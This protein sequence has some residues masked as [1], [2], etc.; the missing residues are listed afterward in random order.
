MVSAE[1]P[2]DLQ[3]NSL[4]RRV[5]GAALGA[6]QRRALAVSAL[7]GVQPITRLASLLGVSRQFVYRQSALASDALDDAFAPCPKEDEVLFHLPVT[8]DW[9]H[10]FALSLVLIGHT[11]LRGVPEILQAV[12]DYHGLSVGSVHNLIRQAVEKARRIH[13]LED[14]RGIR[15]G[16]HD[17]I[18]QAGTPVL[19]G[20][21]LDSTYCYLLNAAEHCDETT[22]GVSLLDLSERGLHL[23]RVIADGGKALRAG[24]SAAWP[25]VPC[26]SDVF[27]AERDLSAVAY[28]LDNRAR[29]CSSARQSLER[30]MERARK[31]KAGCSLSKKLALARSEE[32]KAIS[33]A[34]DIRILADWMRQ[35]ILSGSGPDLPTRR[36]LFDFVVAELRSREPL[37]PHRIGPVLKSLGNQRAGLLAFAGLLDRKL[38]SIAERFGLPAFLVHAVCELQGVDQ[39]SSAYWQRE[40]GLRTKLRHR[41]HDVHV[42]VREAVAST[43]RA[44]SL[45]ENLNSRLRNYFTLRRQ[46]GNDYLDLLRFFLNHRRYLRSDRP[47][48][49]GKSPKE[50]LTGKPHDHWLELLGFSRFRRNAA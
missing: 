20:V 24:Q 46:I 1:I 27:H 34:R 4:L 15:V 42:A 6:E 47:E 3:S 39:A 21:D 28:Y 23:E 33:I 31:R 19:A 14:L 32:A 45:V 16:A 9:I 38:A 7:V 44:S 22:W 48:R 37:C 50:L 36:E 18:Y 43:P 41:F 26:D 25:S 5:G 17:E 49:I 30:K 40:A 35:D 2:C 12:F 11:S 13:A 8:K 29:G 10:Q